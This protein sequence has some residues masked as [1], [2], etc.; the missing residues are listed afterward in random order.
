MSTYSS[1]DEI[2][3]EDLIFKI[4]PGSQAEHVAL[5]GLTAEEC[6]KAMLTLHQP[7]RLD[8]LDDD[9]LAIVGFNIQTSLIKSMKLQVKLDALLDIIEN[10][11]TLLAAA[12][13]L[14]EAS[15]Q[16]GATE[17]RELI[18]QPVTHED[19]DERSYS[20]AQFDDVW[21]AAAIHVVPHLKPEVRR[22]VIAA[23]VFADTQNLVKAVLSDGGTL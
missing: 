6:A 9:D 20:E 5:L 23:T 1:D 21:P 2:L 12:A 17:L 8:V 10:H 22:R 11:G 7:G 16:F 19:Q 13:T 4:M 14:G 15:G 3:D 18:E